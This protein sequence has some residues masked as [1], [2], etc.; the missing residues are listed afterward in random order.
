[1]H[2]TENVIIGTEENIRRSLESVGRDVAATLAAAQTDDKKQA[3]RLQTEK[4][5]TLGIFGSPSFVVADEL[6]WGDDRLEDALE[7]LT[8][9]LPV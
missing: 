5:K 2:W 6:F 4:A 8:T 7:F 1:M 3:L 9:M